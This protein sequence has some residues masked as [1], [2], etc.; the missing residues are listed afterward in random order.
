MTVSE[1][2]KIL[3][4]IVQ[5]YPQSE[6]DQIDTFAVVSDLTALKTTD[7]GLTR[8]DF[9]DGTFWSRKYADGGQIG[10]LCREFPALVVDLDYFM[11]N[12]GVHSV[13][14]AFLDKVRCADCKGCSKS[15]VEVQENIERMAVYVTSRL[16]DY[17]VVDAGSGNFIWSTDKTSRVVGTG[18][19]NNHL[20]LSSEK[21]DIYHYAGGIYIGQLRFELRDCV[22]TDTSGFQPYTTTDKKGVIK[23]KSCG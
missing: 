1:F 2:Y 19:I 3:L 17:G 5:E 6:C 10:T 4:E 23:C 13:S 16:L 12:S 18:D 14:L 7:F 11:I 20:I 22:V 9:D 15:I 21:L 8:D